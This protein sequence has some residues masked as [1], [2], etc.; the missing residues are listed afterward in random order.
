MAQVGAFMLGGVGS[1]C[2]CG[3]PCNTTICANFCGLSVVGVAV[4]V[5]TLGGATVA[6]GTTDASGCVSVAIPG[7]GTYNVT[8]ALSGFTTTTVSKALTCNGTTGVSF[9]IPATLSLTDSSTT[10]TLSF[11]TGSAFPDYLGCYV[12]SV[13]PA[14]PTNTPIPTGGECNP[15][16]VISNPGNCDIVYSLSCGQA[17]AG[18]WILTRTWGCCCWTAI[19]SR[20]P[21]TPVYSSTGALNLTT[22]VGGAGACDSTGS[23]TQSAISFPFSITLVPS[24]ISC[25]PMPVLADPLGLTVSIDL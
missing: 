23:L 8:I 12:L 25:P 19:I 20:P 13:G 2:C 3:G 7:A 10:I 9:P 4:T 21:F 16:S 6:T 17:V 14:A 15:G 22:C 11:V 18:Q 1:P 24:G 5:K